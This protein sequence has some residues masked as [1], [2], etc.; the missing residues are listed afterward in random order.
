VSLLSL[1]ASSGSVSLS[2]I[3]SNHEHQIQTGP[4]NG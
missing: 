4:M 1:V 3:C 2:G